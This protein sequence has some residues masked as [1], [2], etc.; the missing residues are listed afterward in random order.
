M[1]DRSKEMNVQSETTGLVEMEGDRLTMTMVELLI[2]RDNDDDLFS[3]G[4]SRVR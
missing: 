2:N 3:D 1:N 4:A